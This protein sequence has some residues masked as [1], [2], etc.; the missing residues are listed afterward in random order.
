MKN[1][2]N[3]TNSNKLSIYNLP[4]RGKYLIEANAGSG[5]TWQIA[6][7]YCW[8]IAISDEF[9][10]D[11][12]VINTY[13]VAATNEL[14]QRI[15]IRIREYIQA[16]EE[17]NNNKLNLPDIEWQKLLNI[18]DLA[19]VRLLRSQKRAEF[20]KIYTIHGFMQNLLSENT[21]NSGLASE[22]KVAVNEDE[23]KPWNE[24]V[25]FVWRQAMFTNMLCERI[26]NINVEVDSH[27]LQKY[28]FY[29]YPQP[30]SLQDSLNIVHYN[31]GVEVDEYLPPDNFKVN[32]FIKSSQTLANKIEKL[33]PEIFAHTDNFLSQK[34][35]KTEQVNKKLTT[36]IAYLQCACGLINLDKYNKK[37]K[38]YVEAIKSFFQSTITKNI[39]KANKNAW[40]PLLLFSE[41]EDF[42][43][44]TKE[45][46]AQYKRHLEY[47]IYI[48]A[49]NLSEDF[50]STKLIEN[51]KISFNKIINSTHQL[52]CNSS[53][54]KK[55]IAEFQRQTKAMLIDEFQD[56]DRWQWE[57]YRALCADKLL[58][59]A[60]GDPKQ[61]IYKF[62][63]ADIYTYFQAKASMDD[64]L[65]LDGNYR[66]SANVVEAINELF[67][68]ENSFASND[69]NYQAIVAK[70]TFEDNKQIYANTPK[71]YKLLI[72]DTNLKN[73]EQRF[74]CAFYDCAEKIINL[75][76]D[77]PNHT[78]AVLVN[79]NYQCEE[80]VKVLG[81]LQIPA[82]TESEKYS[83]KN[84]LSAL[85][86][87]L[88][89]IS[90]SFYSEKNINFENRSE[91]EFINLI[92]LHKKEFSNVLFSPLWSDVSDD[93]R[94]WQI[95]I[96]HKSI[97][98]QEEKNL[99]SLLKNRL[100]FFANVWENQGLYALI[101]II[102]SHGLDQ[103]LIKYG[104]DSRDLQTLSDVSLYLS[105]QS[106]VFSE[107]IY[108]LNEIINSRI[109]LPCF[110]EIGEGVEKQKT[111][112]G[113]PVGVFTIFKAKGRQ[114][115]FVF[116]PTAWEISNRRNDK[117]QC[118]YESE[119]NKTGWRVN[120]FTIDHQHII[121]NI[122]KNN[123]AESLRKFYVLLTRAIY[124]CFIYWQIPVIKEK[125]ENNHVDIHPQVKLLNN[126]IE[127]IK[128]QKNKNW[129]M[130]NFTQNHFEQIY[131]K[132]LNCQNHA[133]NTNLAHT[134]SDIINND[135]SIT[136]KIINLLGHRSLSFTAINKLFN[137][138]LKNDYLTNSSIN[139]T[140]NIINSQT[141]DLAIE[142]LISFESINHTAEDNI[143]ELEILTRDKKLSDRYSGADFGIAVHTLIAEV[144]NHHHQNPKKNLDEVISNCINYKY[145]I[146]DDND[147]RKVLFEF[148]NAAIQQ[149][150]IN[151]TPPKTLTE[152]AIDEVKPEW[153]FCFSWNKLNIKQ[154]QKYCNLMNFP[155]IELPDTGIINGAIDA[156]I[157]DK[158]ANKYLIIDFKTNILEIKSTENNNDIFKAKQKIIS[159]HHYGLQAA[160]YQLALHYYLSAS[161]PSY[162]WE[163]HLAGVGF[164]FLRA[165]INSQDSYFYFS[166]SDIYF[167]ELINIFE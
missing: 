167:E 45:Q 19:I 59:V 101:K 47:Q 154:W 26:I 74:D 119:N 88:L 120:L 113:N 116:C 9:N 124:G 40:K 58:F 112:S 1:N 92:S 107:Q 162:Q 39:N 86:H 130:I 2:Y 73:K 82:I 137:K 145:K 100:L 8:K 41:I 62:R 160:I 20:I 158:D 68:Q 149:T 138:S 70:R 96:S 16:L 94:F 54:S 67:T 109:N 126:L 34:S 103:R 134:P 49:I 30:Q 151:I 57:I 11:N 37:E 110:E 81:S 105:A 147:Y 53:N 133:E 56:T 75:R 117:L 48:L 7:L 155:Q 31:L 76:A 15:N 4:E 122:I 125:D 135:I 127:D 14:K 3:K 90:Y 95:L 36:A 50:Y 121:N 163:K 21:I 5:K 33:K 63:M 77:E 60:V 108:L 157:Y 32:D 10:V 111:L 91:N 152:L 97:F 123:N 132:L 65:V 83:P 25:N 52:I 79:D 114:W 129:E 146:S 161:L 23:N 131:E 87:L 78:I 93:W 29:K 12:I 66:A 27:Y 46:V 106:P 55:V 84:I 69:I 153:D 143:E 142:D 22:L 44:S 28:F 150:I 166:T 18:R 141:E 42:I 115:D 85:Y 98:T 71:P 17:Q 156:L 140:D 104:W 99:I 164:N 24:A 159:E 80:M 13:T 148:I 89:A 38:D 72:L 128:Q 6:T 64:C 102:Q 61:S 139:V 51:H 35:Y 165:A 136:P 144:I 118:Y 43:N